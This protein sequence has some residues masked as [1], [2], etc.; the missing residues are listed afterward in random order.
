MM[1]VALVCWEKLKLISSDEHD[2]KASGR[3]WSSVLGQ[4]E[5][6]CLTVYVEAGSILRISENC[7]VSLDCFMDVG[8]VCSLATYCGG[9]FP[10][11]KE[12]E[13]E[14]FSCFS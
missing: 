11:R 10:H 12:N 14:E 5:L 13:R 6:Y 1:L 8:T 9:R 3:V 4:I 2:W 7:G